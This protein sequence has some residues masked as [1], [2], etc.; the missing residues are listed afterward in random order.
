MNPYLELNLS[1]GATDAEIRAAYLRLA[2]RHTPT[3]APENFA[4]IA[5]AYALI[6][7]PEKRLEVETLGPPA[8]VAGDSLVRQN[9]G[10]LRLHRPRPTWASLRRHFGTIT[11]ET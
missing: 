3:R 1:P 4:R 6:D 8:G 2:K 10:H 5:K 9:L 7:T 11:P